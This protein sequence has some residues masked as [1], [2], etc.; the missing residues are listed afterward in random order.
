LPVLNWGVFR[1]SGGQLSLGGASKTNPAAG[2]IRAATGNTVTV[3][4]GLATNAGAIDLIGGALENNNRALSNSGI[5]NGCGALR[6]TELTNINK[7][8]LVK[9][10]WMCSAGRAA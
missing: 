3:L 2:L 5:I 1:A 6:T 7:L 9:T 10:I 8:P 4:P